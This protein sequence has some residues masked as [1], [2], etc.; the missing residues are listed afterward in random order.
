MGYICLEI[1][2]EIK[3]VSS[4]E[5]LTPLIMKWSDSIFILD[6]KPAMTFW[7]QQHMDSEKRFQSWQAL[8]VRNFGITMPNQ[9]D[10]NDAPKDPLSLIHTTLVSPRAVY[11]K[12]PFQGLILLEI[13]KTKQSVGLVHSQSKFAK[14]F[15]TTMSWNTWWT[16]VDQII[17]YWDTL[18]PT[19]FRLSSMKKYCSRLKLAAPKLGL[20]SPI[21]A[22]NLTKPGIQRRYGKQL[23]LLLS[24]T[25]SESIQDFPWQVWKAEP[26]EII[27]RYLAYPLN[28]WEY[29]VSYIQKD[30]DKFI[31]SK[32]RQLDE[33][34]LVFSWDIYLENKTIV[35]VFVRFKHPHALH[36]QKGD[37]LTALLHFK[38]AFE[39]IQSETNTLNVIEWRLCI[40]EKINVPIIQTDLWGDY[41]NS[42]G[43]AT[44]KHIENNSSA[45]LM[46]YSM[47][48][49][50][51]PTSSFKEA[52]N[53]KPSLSVTTHKFNKSLKSI[54]KNRP[55][56]LYKRP[57]QVNTLPIRCVSL[58]RTMTKWWEESQ[59]STF[60]DTT[61]YTDHNYYRWKRNG[62]WEWGVKFPSQSKAISYGVFS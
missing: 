62:R 58:E 20:L 25:F 44:F 42:D 17:S 40:E 16:I 2:E 3:D 57:I 33:R 52:N 50:W 30:L 54:S 12:N 29:I 55:L 21:D 48:N 43:D 1:N 31:T 6:L 26:K 28:N 5:C 36:S 27:I 37:H 39:A 53:D 35:P 46:T 47:Q 8:L 10:Q 9:P 24:A 56:F 15:Y 23:A 59:L 4:L 34:V 13:L 49:D 7:L 11:A 45:K 38:L 22:S 51:C 14:H 18:K 41:Q 32:S 19:G 61:S 60:L